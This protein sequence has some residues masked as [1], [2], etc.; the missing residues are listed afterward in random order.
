MCVQP[1]KRLSS[2]III[3]VLSAH[4]HLGSLFCLFDFYFVVKSDCRWRWRLLT[5]FEIRLVAFL[6]QSRWYVDVVVETCTETAGKRERN[7]ER[8]CIYSRVGTT[9][10]SFSRTLSLDSSRGVAILRLNKTKW[11][12]KR[13]SVVNVQVQFVKWYLM[14]IRLAADATLSCPFAC[15]TFIQFASRAF[16]KMKKPEQIIWCDVTHRVLQTVYSVYD[17]T[18]IPCWQQLTQLIRLDSLFRSMMSYAFRYYACMSVVCV[19][20][21]WHLIKNK[22]YNNQL[23]FCRSSTPTDVLCSSSH[24]ILCVDRMC[25]RE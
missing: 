9:L 6:R 11:E 15:A 20:V 2:V 4:A 17:R 24:H 19:G 16:D 1:L 23:D 14:N 10:G 12:N 22:K 5:Y 25:V 18:R 3:D 13:N 7:D 8:S 21:S